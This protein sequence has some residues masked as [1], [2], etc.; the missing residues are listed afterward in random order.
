LKKNIF[1]NYLRSINFRRTSE[2]SNIFP[3]VNK[4]TFFVSLR[5]MYAGKDFKSSSLLENIYNFNREKAR[6]LYGIFLFPW[7][8]Y[9]CTPSR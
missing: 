4:T 9:E 5:E 6:Y 2:I 8:L 1:P 3:A 7:Y